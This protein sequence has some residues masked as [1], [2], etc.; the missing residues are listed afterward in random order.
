MGVRGVR[1]A[2]VAEGQRESLGDDGP[3]LDRYSLR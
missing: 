3:V 2:P 1:L